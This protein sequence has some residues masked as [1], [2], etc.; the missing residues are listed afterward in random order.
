MNE[1]SAGFDSHKSVTIG[2]ECDSVESVLCVCQTLDRISRK[3]KKKTNKGENDKKA[4][5]LSPFE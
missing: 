2:W 3:K 1:G 4:E 5:P